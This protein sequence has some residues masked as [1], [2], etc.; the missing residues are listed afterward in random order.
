MP[1]TAFFT[2]SGKT[3]PGRTIFQA[4]SFPSGSSAAISVVVPERVYR[5]L[6]NRKSGLLNVT[7]LA[8]SINGTRNQ[9]TLRNGLRR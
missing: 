9:N 5:R 8:T 7:I 3:S 4:S 6:K 2:A 1:A